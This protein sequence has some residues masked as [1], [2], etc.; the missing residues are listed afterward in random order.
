MTLCISFG[1]LIHEKAQLCQVQTACLWRLEGPL[2]LQPCGTKEEELV[3][4]I[5]DPHGLY[6]LQ[7]TQG[8]NVSLP[9]WYQFLSLT[10]SDFQA[11]PWPLLQ[12]VAGWP[13]GVRGA[14]VSIS[15]DSCNNDCAMD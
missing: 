2:K 6:P 7:I 14:W 8:V 1:S 12:R 10:N 9:S 4:K 3:Y 5:W 15:E 13:V 11:K